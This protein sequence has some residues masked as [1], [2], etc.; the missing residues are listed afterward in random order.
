MEQEQLVMSTLVYI[1]SNFTRLLLK[2]SIRMK[3]N[4]F[5]TWKLAEIAK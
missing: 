2:L 4:L 5:T 3:A 1:S